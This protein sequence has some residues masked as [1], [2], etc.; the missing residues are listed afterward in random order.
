MGP[1]QYDTDN[2]PTSQ[3][4][5]VAPAIALAGWQLKEDSLACMFRLSSVWPLHLKP[6]SID[7]VA[8]LLLG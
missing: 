6:R 7:A 5:P 2:P 3:A 1:S 8:M 4:G